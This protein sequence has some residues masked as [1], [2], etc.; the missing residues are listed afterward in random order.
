[1]SELKTLNDVLFQSPGVIKYPEGEYFH[2]E[3]RIKIRVNLR[4]AA[5]EWLNVFKKN[6]EAD[7]DDEPGIDEAFIRIFFN[8]EAEDK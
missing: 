5:K 1:M 7:Q 3:E 4:E 6:R 2:A 8:L